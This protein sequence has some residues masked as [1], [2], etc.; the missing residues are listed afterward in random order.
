MLFKGIDGSW[1]EFINE[2]S[3]VMILNSTIRQCFDRAAK[4]LIAVSRDLDPS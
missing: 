2:E 4:I 1:D 3:V